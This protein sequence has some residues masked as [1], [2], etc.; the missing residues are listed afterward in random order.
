MAVSFAKGKGRAAGDYVGNV[1]SEDV[2]GHDD[3]QN[4]IHRLLIHQVLHD[5]GLQR[6]GDGALSAFYDLSTGMI[7]Y[8]HPAAL[9]EPDDRDIGFV[10]PNVRPAAAEQKVGAR[11]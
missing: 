5:E 3:M 11:L 2:S 6:P 1:G 7:R 8:R 4:L 9:D 10:A